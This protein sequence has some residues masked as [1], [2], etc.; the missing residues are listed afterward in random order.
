MLYG[1]RNCRVSDK[2]SES[3]R[4]DLVQEFERARRAQ[5]PF[6]PAADR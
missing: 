3:E 1:T 6:N 5:I 2:E 4:T